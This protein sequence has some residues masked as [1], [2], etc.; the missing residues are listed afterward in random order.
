MEKN[1]DNDL[2]MAKLSSEETKLTREELEMMYFV[3]RMT[4]GQIA[5]RLGV[6]RATIGILFEKH[7]LVKSLEEAFGSLG[8]S[9]SPFVDEYGISPQRIICFKKNERGETV[10]LCSDDPDDRKQKKYY[11]LTATEKSGDLNHVTNQYKKLVKG[12]DLKD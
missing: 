4:P 8:V 2:D 5:E 12:T 6:S 9:V 11:L 7:N 3:E 1:K 10:F